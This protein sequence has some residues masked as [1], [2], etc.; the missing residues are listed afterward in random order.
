MKAGSSQVILWGKI[1]LT[2]SMSWVPALSTGKG[3]RHHQPKRTSL[4]PPLTS[5]SWKPVA[6]SQKS[7]VSSQGPHV[8][9]LQ[10]LKLLFF[11]VLIKVYLIYSVVLFWGFLCSSDSKES[12]CKAGDQGS[13]PGS[14]RSPGEGHGNPLQYS[15][16]ENPMDRGAWWATQPMGLQRV[17]HEWTTE[18]VVLFQVYSKVIQLHVYRYLY[19]HTHTH[20]FFQFF[21]IIGY[22]SIKLFCL[23]FIGKL[24]ADIHTRD[25]IPA[26]SS[27][28][29]ASEWAPTG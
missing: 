29:S 14:G 28:L 1:L 26:S 23:G 5:D 3:G 21:P 7:Q 24:Q 17:R 25:L 6:F 11:L 19:T 13:I 18:H 15:C 12:A 9:E 22:Y 27:S 20:I 8:S 4:W 16:L 2:L 10:G